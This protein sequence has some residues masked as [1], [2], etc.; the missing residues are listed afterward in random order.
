MLPLQALA[1]YGADTKQGLMRCMNQEAFYLKLVR[2][3]VSDTQWGKLRPLIE[4][5]SSREAF[6][7][8]HSLKGVY[9]NLA[10]TPLYE[11][12]SELTERLRNGEPTDVDP[13]LTKLEQ[14]AETL[15]KRT[16]E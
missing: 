14:A 16:E 1:E 2:M 6:E 5:G 3:A 13:V 12:I 10:L 11:P 15:R 7:I 4:S 9:G 8:A